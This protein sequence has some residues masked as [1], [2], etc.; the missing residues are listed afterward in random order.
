MEG[1]W[2]QTRIGSFDRFGKPRCEDHSGVV[3]ILRSRNTKKSRARV[4]GD[5]SMN[6]DLIIGHTHRPTKYSRI[7]FT[8]P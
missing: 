8:E 3:Q 2:R 4:I 6:H 5:Y 1:K 7:K